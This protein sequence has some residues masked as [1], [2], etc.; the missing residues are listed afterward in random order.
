MDVFMTALGAV[1]VKRVPG[2]LPVLRPTHD[3]LIA[4]LQE[5]RMSTRKT[6]ETVALLAA[7]VAEDAQP[8]GGTD[9]KDIAVDLMSD[10]EDPRGKRG[11]V[12]L[13]TGNTA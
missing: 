10:V 1:H 3:A 9:S 5:I 4:K 7:C 13:R 8:R 11:A 2:L 12:A 6:L